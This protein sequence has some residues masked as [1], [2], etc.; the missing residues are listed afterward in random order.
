MTD[1]KVTPP[2]EAPEATDEVLREAGKRALIAEREENKELKRQLKEAKDAKEAADAEKLSNEQ[3]AVRRAEKAEALVAKYEAKET[4]SKL[5]AD[6]AK[7]LEIEDH[8]DLIYG[9]DEASL[10][11]HAEKIKAAFGPTTPEP[12]PYLGKEL[13]AGGDADQDA[14]ALLGF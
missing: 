2:V 12:N 11:A 4:V 9:E 14:R 5:R 1:T 6:I 10:R 3:K 8:A 7:E 13:G